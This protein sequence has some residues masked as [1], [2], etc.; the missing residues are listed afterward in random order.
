MFVNVGSSISGHELSIAYCGKYS[1]SCSAN[2][3]G[4]APIFF[5]FEIAKFLR[6]KK[7]C[8][9]KNMLLTLFMCGM[10]HVNMLIYSLVWCSHFSVLIKVF[11]NSLQ[12]SAGNYRLQADIISVPEDFLSSVNKRKLSHLHQS[13]SALRDLRKH[14]VSLVNLTSE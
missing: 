6:R 8:S 5:F 9:K 10:P 13:V 3:Q 12:R 7:L 4:Y 14:V 11:Q 2:T 1:N